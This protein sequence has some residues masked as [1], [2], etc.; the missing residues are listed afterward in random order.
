MRKTLTLIAL[1]GLAAG[2]ARK[3]EATSLEESEL[4]ASLYR[5]ATTDA[6][7]EEAFETLQAQ[8]LQLRG[9]IDQYDENEPDDRVFEIDPLTEADMGDVPPVPGTDTAEQT[10]TLT[11]YRSSH[12]FDELF[13]LQQ[14]SNQNC[15]G[16]GSTVWSERVFTSNEDCFFD[17]S[18][19]YATSDGESRTENVLAKV[20]IQSKA[21][22]R[23]IVVPDEEGGEFEALVSRGW[24]EDIMV[25]DGGGA[26]WRQRYVLDV[27]IEDGDTTLRSYAF[28]SEA[29]IPFVGSDL[30]VAQVKD[31]IEETM[32][33]TDAFLDGEVCEDRDAT[34]ADFED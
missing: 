7:D 6:E 28:W 14:D 11:Y 24:I 25:G 18:C 10:P 29:A 4:Q 33:N 9:V 19:D 26:E 15:L 8:L 21:D 23:R 31:G 20:W 17:K 32:Q 12:S 1:A 16:S 22:Y 34:R 13:A 3:L 5:T 27:F 2:C 30:Y